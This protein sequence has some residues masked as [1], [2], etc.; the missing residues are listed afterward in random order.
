M[1]FMMKSSRYDY[2]DANQMSPEGEDSY[3][4]LSVL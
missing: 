3:I 1:E 4:G 2:N